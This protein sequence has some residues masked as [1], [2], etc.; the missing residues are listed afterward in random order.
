ME[1]GLYTPRRKCPWGTRRCDFP[2]SKLYMSYVESLENRNNAVDGTFYDAINF[3]YPI[4][5]PGAT[6]SSWHRLM[7][8][9]KTKI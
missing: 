1:K 3:T 7:H 6:A 4:L 2:G 8:Q 5:L 9:V